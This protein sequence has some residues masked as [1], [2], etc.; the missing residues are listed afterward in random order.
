MPEGA[1]VGPAPV[2]WWHLGT[3]GRF[4]AEFA[5]FSQFVR[6]PRL[7]PRLPRAPGP[8][9]QGEWLG[10]LRLGHLFCWVLLLWAINLMVL[11]PVAATAA[12]FAGAER[13]V[14]HPARYRMAA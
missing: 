1:G 7:S 14:R 5:D 4:K 2:R 11:G 10:G 12:S 3:W 9:W 13:T 8:A 6:H